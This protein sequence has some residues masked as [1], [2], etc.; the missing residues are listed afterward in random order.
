MDVENGVWKSVS[1]IGLPN[2]PYYIGCITINIMCHSKSGG[3]VRIYDFYDETEVFSKELCWGCHEVKVE[4]KKWGVFR[5]QVSGENV[6][7]RG[8]Q[9]DDLTYSRQ[10]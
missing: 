4:V 2:R 3:A 1:Q 8:C 7:F 9:T 6:S 5:I 10:S